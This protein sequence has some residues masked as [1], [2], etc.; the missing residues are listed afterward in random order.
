MAQNGCQEPTA[1][2]SCSTNTRPV[3]DSDN[4]DAT[5]KDGTWMHYVTSVVE[6]VINVLILISRPLC[7]HLP[8]QIMS[9]YCMSDSLLS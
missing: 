3:A 1:N 7:L 4:S 5:V 6:I 9:T 2:I 8:Q